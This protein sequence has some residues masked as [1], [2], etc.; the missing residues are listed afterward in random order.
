M[1]SESSTE[2]F[3]QALKEQISLMQTV[4]EHAKRRKM[5][6]CLLWSQYNSDKTRQSL[7]KTNQL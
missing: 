5:L 4:S 3:Y 2:E 6:E 1:A 7:Y